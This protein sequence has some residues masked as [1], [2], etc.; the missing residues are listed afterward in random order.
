MSQLGTLTGWIAAVLFGVAIG[1]SLVNRWRL[2][3]GRS[4]SMGWVRAHNWLGGRA[5]GGGGAHLPSVGHPLAALRWTELLDGMVPRSQL[6][7]RRRHG[8]GGG[9]LPV[10]GHP[11]HT[12]RGRGD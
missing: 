4:F 12:S 7:G 1:S 11:D 5:T 3:A 2:S 8:G 9:A 10:V 6:A